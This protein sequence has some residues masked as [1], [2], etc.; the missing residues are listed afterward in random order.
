MTTNTTTVW[1]RL[2]K[3]PLTKPKRAPKPEPKM[4]PVSKFGRLNKADQEVLR[5]CVES[6]G[7]GWFEKKNQKLV[8]AGFVDEKAWE[9]TVE[10]YAA[11]GKTKPDRRSVDEKIR[12]GYYDPTAPYPRSKDFPGGRTS[13]EFQAALKSYCEE[14]G[15]LNEQ[16][17]LDLFKEE[18]VEDNPKREKCYSIAYEHGHSAGK[19]EVSIYFSEFVELIK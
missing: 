8:E 14:Q 16:F 12:D 18:G 4:D 6:D 5:K 9:I 17:K 15:R 10:G 2:D 1:D 19:S 11:L 13:P 3:D 7:M